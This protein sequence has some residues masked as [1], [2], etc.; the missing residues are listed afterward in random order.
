V[1]FLCREPFGK[2]FRSF[3]KERPELIRIEHHPNN[4]LALH[5]AGGAWPGGRRTRSFSYFS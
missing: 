5:R 1:A 4:L 3:A 2:A